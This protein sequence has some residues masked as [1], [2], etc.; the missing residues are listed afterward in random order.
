MRELIRLKIKIFYIIFFALSLL[1]CNSNNTDVDGQLTNAPQADGPVK[2][3][4]FA[5]YPYGAHFQVS[6]SGLYEILLASCRRCGTE[7]FLDY[8]GGT[9]YQK[10]WVL[11]DHPKRCRNWNSQAYM[12][13]IFAERK[14]P[15]QAKVLIQPKYTGTGYIAKKWG[16]PFEI[17]ATARAINENKGFQILVNPDGGLGGIRSLNIQSRSSNHVNQSDLDI[18]VTYGGDTITS[19]TLKL[20]NEPSVNAPTYDCSVYTN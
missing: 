16:E 1:S 11:K 15:T 12:Q 10:S 20:L 19:S 9:V 17:K 7:R 8:P 4:E 2:S 3:V 13:I 18:T 6:H 5:G 14:L